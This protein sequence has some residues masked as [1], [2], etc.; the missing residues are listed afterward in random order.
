MPGHGDVIES[1]ESHR[2]DLGDREITVDAPPGSLCRICRIGQP[3]DAPVVDHEQIAVPV[4]S[5]RPGVP[6]MRTSVNRAGSGARSPSNATCCV[7]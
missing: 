6:V 2:I 7:Y 5:D 3:I 4:K 1:I